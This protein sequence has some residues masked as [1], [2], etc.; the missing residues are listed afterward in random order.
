[1]DA[2]RFAAPGANAAGPSQPPQPQRPPAKKRARNSPDG[3]GRSATG[4]TGAGDLSKV[5]AFA[6]CR[7]CRQKK[8]K[9]LPGPQSGVNGNAAC[10]Q[11]IMSG[12][13]CEYQP[14]RD[15]AA[16]SRAY[17]QDLSGRVQQLEALQS[18]ILPLLNAFEGGKLENF[19]SGLA[20][21]PEPQSM[22]DNDERD[23][24]GDSR[25]HSPR[26]DDDDDE[27]RRF[28]QDDR[29]NFRWIG[30]SNTLSLL[31]SFDQEVKAQPSRVTYRPVHDSTRASS[32]AD[33]AHPYFGPVAGAGVI[34]ALPGVEEV[35]FP[36]RADA[37]AM[38]DAY[39]AEVHPVLPVLLEPDF[40]RRLNR[41][42]DC[43][44]AGDFGSIRAGVSTAGVSL[45]IA[46]MSSS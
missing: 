9:C 4:S 5:R 3:P 10:Q 27:G 18:R 19:V 26:G 43:A 33:S 17:V 2:A 7:A 22:S 8:V 38:V 15:R 1:M 25:P 11:C 24:N 42:L 37:E 30:P 6:A 21:K 32:P 39:F 12:A 13:E 16:Y 31:D 36:P 40:R 44:E 34:R 23:M 41:A 28:Q 14:T 20:A 35:T 29:G 45:S 46:D